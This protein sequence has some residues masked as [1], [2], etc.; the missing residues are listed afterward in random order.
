MHKNYKYNSKN[1]AALTSVTPQQEFCVHPCNV[2]DNVAEKVIALE[3]GPKPAI[4]VRHFC[5]GCHTVQ[6]KCRKKLQETLHCVSGI[7]HLLDSNNCR[8]IGRYIAYQR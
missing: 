6:Q 8:C 7:L 1:I 5:R 3:P 4:I 2:L